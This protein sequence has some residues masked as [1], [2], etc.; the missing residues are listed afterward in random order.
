LTSALAALV[1]RV[2]W[3]SQSGPVSGPRRATKTGQVHALLQLD[4]LHHRVDLRARFDRHHFSPPPADPPGHGLSPFKHSKNRVP[5]KLPNAKSRRSWNATWTGYPAS[6]LTQGSHYYKV[7]ALDVLGN[8]SETAK[9]LVRIDH[10]APSLSLSG[11]MTQQAFLG[12]KRPQYVLHLDGADGTTAGPQSEIAS[13]EI[14]V[15]GKPSIRPKP[16]ARRRTAR[17]PATGRSKPPP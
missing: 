15:D 14:T 17:S 16:G 5:P 1:W 4:Y 6:S 7:T 11:T 2:G 9:V 13:S 8:E 10:T 3:G 12:Y